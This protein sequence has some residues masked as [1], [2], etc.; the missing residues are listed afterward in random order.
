M[1]KIILLLLAFLIVFTGVMPV[2]A[3]ESGLISFSIEPICPDQKDKFLGI[4]VELDDTYSNSTMLVAFYM[5]GSLT[6]LTPYDVSSKKEFTFDPTLTRDKKK[7]PNLFQQET[8]VNTYD[9][10]TTSSGKYF[11]DQTPDKI[12]IFTWDKTTLKPK[13]LCDD[14]LTPDVIKAA[15]ADVVESLSIIPEATKHIRNKC[16]VRPEDVEDGSAETWD[17]NLFAIMDHLDACA[18]QA[19]EDAET[20]LM[21]S[22]YAQSQYYDDLSQV[23]KLAN[24]LTAQEQET[25]DFILKGTLK[26]SEFPTEYYN[27]LINAMK[28][29]DFSLS[30]IYS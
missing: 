25:M 1:K 21:T 29:L 16:L 7:T 10:V 23:R 2:Y 28:F 24:N 11:A 13:T 19:T 20:H 17:E 14:V 12:K 4:N 27:A 18:K 22:L 30:D 3:L 6:K 26:P 8:L 15:N 5:N 9:T